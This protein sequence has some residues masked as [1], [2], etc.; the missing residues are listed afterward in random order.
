MPVP[1]PVE[2]RRPFDESAGTLRP[3]AFKRAS[4]LL[5]ESWKAEQ[6]PLNIRADGYELSFGPK[7]Y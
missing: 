7:G 1:R 3:S 6:F 4:D 5:R 2:T